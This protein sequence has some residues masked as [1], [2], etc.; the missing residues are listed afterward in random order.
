[1]QNVI[2]RKAKLSD[3]DA[4]LK[5]YNQGIE[6]RIA[7]LETELKDGHFISDWFNKHQGRYQVI[8]AQSGEDVVGWVSLN[9]YNARQAYAG[10]AELSIYISRSHRGKG[11]GSLLLKSAERKAKEYGFHKIVLFT[12]LFNELGQGLYRKF[13]YR[14]VGV[15]MKQGMM[16]GEL[17]DVMA[18]E[19]L[20]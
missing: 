1:M 6:D 10:V 3:L 9:P 20:L 14:E 4:I 13:G 5:I 16:D 12:F 19:K 18:M 2:C 7:T 15:F 17:V 8:V 11:I